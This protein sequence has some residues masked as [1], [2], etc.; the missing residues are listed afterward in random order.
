MNCLECGT[1]LPRAGAACPN[2]LRKRPWRH[3]AVLA[4][5]LGVV[6]LVAVAFAVRGRQHNQERAKLDAEV[7]QY[8]ENLDAE[9]RGKPA[10]E[11]LTRL[12]EP[13]RRTPHKGYVAWV[14]ATPEG[15]P[16][17]V[18]IYAGKVSHVRTDL[19]E[20]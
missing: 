9:L 4:G 5:L 20:G 10:S 14:Y 12:G 1:V 18:Y 8:C 7:K 19:P 16:F 3:P 2:C 11:A 17:A 6:G 15:V 13:A